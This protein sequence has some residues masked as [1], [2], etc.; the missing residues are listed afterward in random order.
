MPVPMRPWLPCLRADPFAH[1]TPSFLPSARRSRLLV[2]G[3]SSAFSST[4]L[5]GRPSAH[6][7]LPS[8]LLSAPFPPLVP[9]RPRRRY[10]KRIFKDLFER[11][12]F[13]DDGVYDWDLLKKQQEQGASKRAR[14]APLR[15]VVVAVVV[16][17]LAFC[18]S[19]ATR[20]SGTRRCHCRCHTDRVLC[21]LRDC[22][23][24]QIDVI[25]GRHI[26]PLYPTRTRAA[27]PAARLPAPHIG[28]PGQGPPAH[29][30]LLAHL[31]R[32]CRTYL[33]TF[34]ICT[35]RPPV[36]SFDHP[37]SSALRCSWA[38]FTLSH[39]PCVARGPF[40]PCLI[41]LALLV[42]RFLFH[43]SGRAGRPPGRRHKGQDARQRGA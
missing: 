15:V 26:N 21:L 9:R 2:A 32:H 5:S 13:E 27:A 20:A 42:G 18:R 12:A 35:I 19:S 34:F 4:C 37:V 8:S 14:D 29:T 7:S 36:A 24:L 30:S 28:A 31:A 1:L 23:L 40:S 33:I 3:I 22:S 6:T 41:R 25:N 16:V 10:L 39:P 38:V 11:Q 17:P 43:P